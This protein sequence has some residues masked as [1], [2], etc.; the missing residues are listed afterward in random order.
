M[1]ASKTYIEKGAPVGQKTAHLSNEEYNRAMQKFIKVCHDVVVIDER[2]QWLLARRRAD[3]ATPGLWFIGGQMKPFF[4]SEESLRLVFARETGLNLECDRF[5]FILEN[6]YY[7]AATE[8]DPAHD[9]LC[10]VYT[11]TLSD[12]EIARVRLDPHEYD[13][14]GLVPIDESHMLELNE[15]KREIFSDFRKRVATLNG[16]G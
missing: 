12:D 6:R 3:K 7:I 2:G 15:F 8:A 1:A 10:K 14:G 11:V 4:T 9:A 5:T 13:S 16:A